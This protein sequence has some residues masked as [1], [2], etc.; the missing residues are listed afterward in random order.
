MAT[1]VE[2]FTLISLRE[3]DSSKTALMGTKLD[4]KLRLEECLWSNSLVFA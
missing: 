1:L 4:L 2:Q 3:T